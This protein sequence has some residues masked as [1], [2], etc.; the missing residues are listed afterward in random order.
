[1]VCL[2]NDLSFELLSYTIVF[3]FENVCHPIVF[4]AKLKVAQL[5]LPVDA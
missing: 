2:V 3:M 4:S 5:Y 1:M